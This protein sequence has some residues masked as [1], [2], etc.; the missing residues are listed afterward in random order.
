MGSQGRQCNHAE[1]LLIW[2]SATGRDLPWRRSRDPWLVLVSEFM[3]QQTQ[4]IRVVE[5][6]PRFL[7]RFPSPAALAQRPVAAVISEWTGLGYNRRAVNL[8]RA[9]VEI[10]EKH[11]GFV[12]SDMNSLL[13]LPGVGPYTARAVRVFAFEEHD[14]VVDTNIGRVLARWQGEPLMPTEVQ[15]LADE[16]VPQDDPWTWNQAI[17]ELGARVCSRSPQCNSC[18]VSGHCTWFLNGCADPDPA[19]RSAGVSQPQS[20]FEGSDRQGRALL[21]R[22]LTAGPLDPGELATTMGWPNDPNRAIRVI[23]SLLRDGLVVLSA[24]GRYRLPE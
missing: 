16:L 5:R 12:P 13:A 20:R 17:M 22:A 24:E 23:R 8:H 3:L 1:A 4:V 11:E 15:R 14:A 18:P 2:F 7:N 19:I 21:V 10:V 9:A 6:L